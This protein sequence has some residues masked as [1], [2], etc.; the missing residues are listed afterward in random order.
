MKYY[1]IK[2]VVDFRGTYFRLV[3]MHAAHRFRIR[4]FIRDDEENSLSI[5]A[6]GGLN[7]NHQKQHRIYHKPYLPYFFFDQNLIW[8][9]K[10]KKSFMDIEKPVMAGRKQLQNNFNPYRC[11]GC[12]THHF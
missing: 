8:L 1:R 9:E 7:D 2:I 5:E 6:Y 4:G 10:Q 3:A 11:K 12:D